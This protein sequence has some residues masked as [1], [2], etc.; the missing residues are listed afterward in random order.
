[1]ELFTRVNE[2]AAVL[3]DFCGLTSG[4]RVTIHMPMIP[5]LPIT[6]LA[7]ARLGIIHSVVFGGFSGEAAGLRRAGAPSRVVIYGDAYYRN[8]KLVEHKSNANIALDVAAKAGTTVEKVLVWRR[9]R[10][11][12]LSTTPMIAGRDYFMDELVKQIA[13]ARVDP[14]SMDAESP[15]FLM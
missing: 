4:D 2:V 14:V 6:M 15:L 1:Q 8:G 7:C 12:S 9:H 11:Q 3:R 10:G 5:E 13:G